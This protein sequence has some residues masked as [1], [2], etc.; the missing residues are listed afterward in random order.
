MTKQL[1][2]LAIAAAFGIAHAADAKPA[3]QQVAAADS[4]QTGTSQSKVGGPDAATGKAP[5]MK[6]ETAT[7]AGDKATTKPHRK[8]KRTHKK[9]TKSESATPAT[10]A[11]PASK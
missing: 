5:E 9:S 2:A 6:T 3:A 4:T 1:I 7:N 11:E 8:A 10:P